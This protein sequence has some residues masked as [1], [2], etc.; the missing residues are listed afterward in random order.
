MEIALYLLLG[1]AAGIGGGLFGIGGGII[2]VPALVLLAGFTQQKAQGTSLV[3]LLAPVGI[4][5]LINYYKSENVDFKV[6]AFIALG[7][8]GGG[9]FG[10]KIALG[11]S[12][13]VMR[14]AFSVF[15]VLVA[16][17]MW[18]KKG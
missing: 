9:Y 18:F 12:P 4:F 3:A 8:L 11:L 15:L 7:F 6:G 10:S 2:I 16:L 14:K 1:L 13:D 5:A 17:S